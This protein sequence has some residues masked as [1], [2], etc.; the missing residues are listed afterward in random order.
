MSLRS[1]VDELLVVDHH[2]HGVLRRDV[3]RADFE[4]MLTEADDP[5]R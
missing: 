2:C 3:N 1:T 4:S 5:A